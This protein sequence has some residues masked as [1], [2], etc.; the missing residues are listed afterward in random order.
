VV[1][2][3]HVGDEVVLHDVSNLVS[4]GWREAVGKTAVVTKV[5]TFHLSVEW[6]LPLRLRS[7]RETYHHP[8]STLNITRFKKSTGPW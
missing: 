7:G 6:T 8:R 5:G 3:F 1:D 4:I 2:E